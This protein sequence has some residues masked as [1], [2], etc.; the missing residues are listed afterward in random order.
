MGW[1]KNER[2]KKGYALSDGSRYIQTLSVIILVPTLSL[3]PPPIFLRPFVSHFVLPVGRDVVDE[4]LFVC[5]CI[6]QHGLLDL[7]WKEACCSS[8][9]NASG[10]NCLCLCYTSTVNPSFRLH[11]FVCAPFSSNVMGIEYVPISSKKC[12]L[13]IVVPGMIQAS[14]IK[15]AIAVVYRWGHATQ[16]Q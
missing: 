2:K 13:K 3:L 8:L 6:D 15:R 5:T 14:E 1:K 4:T 9:H 7:R 16:R 12:R 11:A 10:R